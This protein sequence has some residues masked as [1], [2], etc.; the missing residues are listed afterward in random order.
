[1]G[2]PRCGFPDTRYNARYPWGHKDLTYRIDSYPS[3]DMT[4]QD[5]DNTIAE[6]FKVCIMWK[7]FFVN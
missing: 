6:A 3:L 5:V 4:N 7:N 1:M 2:A